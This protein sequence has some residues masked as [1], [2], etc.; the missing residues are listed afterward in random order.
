MHSAP[1]RDPVINS[2]LKANKNFEVDIVYLY[3]DGI[4]SHPEWNLDHTK[5]E[6]IAHRKIKFLKKYDWHVGILNRVW[7][8]DIIFIG[9][10]YPLI[11]LVFLIKAILLHKKVIF[12][13]DTISFKRSIFHNVIYKFVKRS[14]AFFVPGLKSKEALI[15]DLGIKENRIFCGAYLIDSIDWISRLS[16]YRKENLNSSSPFKLLFVGQLREIRNTPLL[17]QIIENLRLKS[18]NVELVYIGDGNWYKEALS[19]QIFRGGVTWIPAVSYN[20]LAEYY[21]KADCYIHPGKEPY[22]LALSQ[23]A[24]A[25]IPIISHVAVGAVDDYIV[26]G[27]NGIVVKDDSVADFVDAVLRIIENKK[28]FLDNA[29]SFAKEILLS[30]SITWGKIQLESAIELCIR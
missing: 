20:S 6:V 27:Y 8:Y 18:V 29:K 5:F 7:K 21:A 12:S 2:F 26:D 17:M 1:Y 13:C 28:I 3:A 25:G 30:H 23:A 14:S 10:Y 15:N 22:S 19:Q 16:K 9:G 11:N 4:V 24:F